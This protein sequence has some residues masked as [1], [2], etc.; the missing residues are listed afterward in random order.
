MF[1]NCFVVLRTRGNNAVCSME[2]W[3][4]ANQNR[5]F[6]FQKLLLFFFWK[7]ESAALG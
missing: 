4:E 2:G 5:N 3:K 1:A 6:G 7:I